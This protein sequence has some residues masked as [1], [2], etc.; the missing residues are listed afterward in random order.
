MHNYPPATIVNKHG[1][2]KWYA[3]CTVPQHLQK[4]LGKKQ[5]YRSLKTTDRQD[6]KRRLVDAQNKIHELFR[7]TEVQEVP[8]TAAYIAFEEAFHGLPFAQIPHQERIAPNLWTEK[9]DA[10]P[11]LLKVLLRYQDRLV[12]YE[13]TL[14]KRLQEQYQRHLESD[15]PHA[16]LYE[17]DDDPWEPDGHRQLE[18]FLLEYKLL[19]GGIVP[20]L[21]AMREDAQ[22]TLQ[23][24]STLQQLWAEVKDET[25]TPP[26]S[27]LKTF[28]EVA[29]EYLSSTVF[30]T[31]MKG[32]GKTKSY[33]T[34][35][36]TKTGIRL[37][38]NW[39]KDPDFTLGEMTN[40]L[41]HQYCLAL[42]DPD[43][44]LIKAK[45][46]AVGIGRST[47]KKRITAVRA[48]LA[49]AKMVGYV[50]TNTWLG[51]E[52]ER[53]GVNKPHRRRDWTEQELEALFKLDMPDE[54]RLAFTL[55]FATGARLEEIVSLRLD[56]IH[57]EEKDGQRLA[58][59]DVTESVVKNEQSARIIP[60]HPAVMDLLPSKGWNKDDAARLFSYTIKQQT[61]KA[62]DNASEQLMKHVNKVRRHEKDYA[63]SVHSLR[64]NFTTLCREHEVDSEAREFMVGRGGRGVGSTTY[65]AIHTVAAF[66]K[67]LAKIPNEEFDVLRVKPSR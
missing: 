51:L 47:I 35:R 23:G 65:G 39:M 50:E 11:H 55:L 5:V 41:G 25:L 40:A 6:A 54:D 36:E 24:Q 17:E 42:A 32:D 44:K 18:A 2:P 12:D 53:F 4:A 57:V 63:L 26:V 45:D 27:Q 29:E 38:T 30:T 64:H 34:M 61:G 7:T 31:A 14:S 62:S 43:T 13:R 15:D 49:Y 60:V 1:T 37:F 48:V 58:W 52:L 33:A 28:N 20:D 66:Y 22:Q 8:I 9:D 3:C 59:L 16:Y 10:R 67:H 21:N 19:K 46:G 56:Q